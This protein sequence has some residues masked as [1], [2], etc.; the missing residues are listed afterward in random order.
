MN[1][2]IMNNK[3]AKLRS[4][5]LVLLTS[6]NLLLPIFGVIFNMIYYLST[7]L[8]TKEKKII[9]LNIAF[10]MA[11]IRHSA[12]IF[13]FK[14]ERIMLKKSQKGF[15][16]GDKRSCYKKYGSFRINSRYDR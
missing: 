10:S 16:N 6:L 3:I 5:I 12:P 4:Y 13:L 14:K 7:E 8:N 11:F 15:Y 2:K 1:N 9:F